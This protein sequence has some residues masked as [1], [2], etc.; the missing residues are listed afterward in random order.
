MK[1]LGVLC[2]PREGGNTNILLQQAL[3]SAKACGA[4]TEEITTFGKE[5]KPCDGCFSCV[6]T[7]ECHIDDDMQEIY[8]RLLNADG[9]IWATPV[10][11]FNVAAQTKILI[12]RSHVL[13]V[14]GKLAN[15]T[16][17]VISVASSLGHQNVWDLFNAFFSVNH[18]LIADFVWGF[19]REMG[20]IHKDRHAMQATKE[21][22]KQVVSMIERKF[23]YPKEYDVPLYAL[24]NRN[25]GIE[26]CP[27]RGRFK[28][29]TIDSNESHM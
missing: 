28:C 14:H 24:V 12:D 1:V 23:T 10:Y 5:L 27:A 2:S 8:P 20:D 11:F 21:L 4:D 9:I 26:T 18:M 22:G 7:S 3:I 13:Y 6:E 19:A 15:K 17:G 25:Y 16:G 29:Q